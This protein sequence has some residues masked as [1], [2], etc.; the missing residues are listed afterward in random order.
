MRSCIVLTLDDIKDIF[1]DLTKE[2][3]MIERGEHR[4]IYL[5]A[6]ED[7]EDRLMKY[8]LTSA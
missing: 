2:S 8:K 5:G 3:F 6:I 4:D 1:I 7:F